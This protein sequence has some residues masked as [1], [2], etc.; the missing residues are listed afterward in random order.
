LGACWAINNLT[1]LRTAYHALRA[2]VRR[3]FFSFAR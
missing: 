1:W 2:S 3:M